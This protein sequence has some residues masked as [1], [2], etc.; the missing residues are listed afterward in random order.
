MRVDDGLALGRREFLGS[1]ALAGAALV[2]GEAAAQQG[3]RRTFRGRSEDDWLQRLASQPAQRMVSRHS[4]TAIVYCL[5]LGDGVL[6]GFKAERP[7]QEM[8]WRHEIVSYRFGRLL[9][10]ES[11]I[12]PVTG[13]RVPATVFGRYTASDRLIVQ[14]DQT[15]RGSASVWMPVL[16]GEQLHAGAPRRQWQSWLAPRGVI[17]PERNERAKQ[18][19]VILVFDWLMS[20]YDRWNCCNIP[21]DEHGQVVYRDNDAG[22][23]A[24]V[25]GRINSPDA[26][27]RLPRALWERLRAADARAFRAEVERDPMAGVELINR[28]SYAVY[29]RRRQRLVAHIEAQIARRGEADVL[30]WP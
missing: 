26:I 25:M 3:G 17:P 8:W 27:T 4:S 1:C 21:I 2:A 29:E 30:V 23:F 28:A 19:A 16:R 13:K 22:W 15:V 14:S 12:P 24:P 7:G 10:I 9:G 11:R 5:D 6:T 18:I 20:N